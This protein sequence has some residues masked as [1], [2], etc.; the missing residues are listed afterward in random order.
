[1]AQKT[2]P[3]I[4]VCLSPSLLPQVPI[5]D[6]VVVVIDVLR[7]TTSLAVAFDYGVTEVIPTEKINE[8]ASYGEKGYLTAAERGGETVAGFDFGNS[9]YAFMSDE[10]RGAR[11][12]VTTT[13]GT[14]AI[15]AARAAGQIVTGAF[16]NQAVLTAYLAQ[17]RWPVVLLCAGW[18]LS[19]NLEDTLFAGAMVDALRGHGFRLDDDA[20]TI[21]SALYRSASADKRFYI[22]HSSHLRRLIDLGLQRDVKYCLRANTHPVL[23]ALQDGRLVNLLASAST[24]D[25]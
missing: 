19:P 22:Q 4:R 18:R 2:A 25:H 20:A 9:P 3:G 24:A 10:L 23:P 17:K 15:H 12:A 5:A 14:Q 1:M 7:F 8:A 13:N 21:A 11:L 16:A 6:A